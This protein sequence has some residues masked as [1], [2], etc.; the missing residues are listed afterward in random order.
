MSSVSETD[1][2]PL[3][4]SMLKEEEPHDE[5]EDHKDHHDPSDD[6]EQ[7]HAVHEKK[8][9]DKVEMPET[10]R[11]ALDANYI[12]AIRQLASRWDRVEDIDCNAELVQGLQ[13]LELGSNLLSVHVLLEASD[14]LDIAAN[15]VRSDR[16][17]DKNFQSARVCI[18]LALG[19]AAPRAV[20]EEDIEHRKDLVIR[21]YRDTAYIIFDIALH[22]T[23][24]LKGIPVFR[25]AIQ[26]FVE[27]VKYV[28]HNTHDWPDAKR[29]EL[30][31]AIFEHF[32]N[33]DVIIQFN[34][35][36]SG[37]L[38]KIFR[39]FVNIY[40]DICVGIWTDNVQ[41]RQIAEST[42]YDFEVKHYRILC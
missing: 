15:A 27:F 39:E 17:N 1:A 4:L 14:A 40:H 29:Q 10:L 16:V 18:D 31:L 3:D 20:R 8:D 7:D 12:F 11:A 36:L 21:L 13:G 26:R 33:F 38:R 34:D 9:D 41:A 6:H 35:S 37:E 23:E 42:A 30:A 22:S 25:Y 19:F 2:P 28:T 32:K 5:D 24:H